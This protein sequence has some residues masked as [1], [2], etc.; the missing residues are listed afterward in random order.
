MAGGDLV[1]TI[2]GR[3]KASRVFD[4]VG[5]SMDRMGRRASK[6]FAGIAA[7]SA[8]SSAAVASAVGGLPAVFAGMG[9]VALRNNNEVRDSFRDL[10]TEIS[11]GI[12]QDAAP[13][14][15]AFVGAAE[16]ISTA[17]QEMRPQLREAFAE[18]VPAVEQLTAGVL[19][20]TRNAMPGM[21]DMLQQSTPVLA[22]LRRMMEDTGV[23]ASEF[24]S[25]LS[26][27]AQEAG[28]G[29]E[30]L[31]QLVRGVLPETG[32]I[33][34]TLSRL[35]AEHGDQVADVVT[36]LVGVIGDLSGSALPVV[37]SALGT[38]LSV[39]EGVLGV[40][41]PLTG[42]IGPLIG[43]WLALGTAMKAIRGVR[44]V[45]DSVATSVSN[46]GASV[47]AAAGERGVGKM[48][49]AVRGLSGLLGGPWGL[50]VAGATAALAAFGSS[51]QQTAKDQR[52]LADALRDSGGQFDNNAR[53]A[54]FQSESY[55]QVKDSVEA[56]GIS[57]DEF[58]DAVTK[59]GP[60]LDAL[61]SRLEETSESGTDYKI[62]Q[63]GVG[64]AQT[65]AA[66]AADRLLSA[67]GG[68]RNMITG[69]AD[70][71]RDY[72]SAVHGASAAT[73][74]A[75]PGLESAREAMETL[76]NDT[77]DT[78][79]RVDALNDA[80]RKLLGIEL[81]LEEATAQWRE[82]LAG[83][84][85]HLTGVK[86]DSDN[87]RDALF[88]ANGAINLSTEEGRE[89]SEQLIQ[90]GE[91][92]RELAQTAYDT[93]LRQTGSHKRAAA[94]AVESA[95]DRRSAFI[96]EMTQMTGNERQARRLADRYLGL[97]DDVITLIKARD[98]ATGV[99]NDIVRRN[100][101]RDIHIDVKARAMGQI[102]TAG[103]FA[104]G[105]MVGRDGVPG[106][107]GGGLLR[108]R[109]GPRDDA[110]LIAASDGEFVVNARDTA[111]NLGLLRA[112][113]SGEMSSEARAAVHAT[114]PGRTAGGAAGGTQRVVVEFD[115][116]GAD[117]D[118]VN[119]LRNA[120]RVRGGNVQVVLGKGG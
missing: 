63:E 105:G 113:N 84:R 80:W 36:R 42:A 19:G 111:R 88:K 46:M 103:A 34:N 115:F 32:E 26:S 47:S 116:T 90:Q 87:W 55:Q 17:Y 71:A 39:L 41:E 56:A 62:T 33:L 12:A 65:S 49:T 20:F 9:A 1:F 70:D 94:A 35:W 69:A 98:N 4:D 109:G 107:P 81:S 54:L 58:I 89:L 24:F 96:R 112:I 82:G 86:E 114:S 64:Q 99:V 48:R 74:S 120:V 22:G 27:G 29:V 76:G 40:I 118:L 2:L 44:G 83:L 73:R 25:V 110:N 95:N 77:A 15:D 8:A 108:G 11:T 79:D 37:S 6:V 57:H 45:A 30:H 14:K 102:G 43:A 5:K 31:G 97:P 51:S 61:R 3:D 10:S 78:A 38:T 93:T 60:A 59:G 53:A 100:N 72:A 75:H 7:S 85:E 117:R 23:G 21:L 52:S 16:D 50:A 104:D 66:F 68:L 28:Q 119:V 18:S 91:D 106:F 101:G 67:T 92:Y 13:L